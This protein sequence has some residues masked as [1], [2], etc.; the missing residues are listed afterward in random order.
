MTG[1]AIIVGT[2]FWFVMFLGFMVTFFV[3]FKGGFGGK[4]LVEGALAVII[5]VTL[6]V[7][8]SFIARKLS[9]RAIRAAG[10]DDGSDATESKGREPT[11]RVNRRSRQG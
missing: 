9:G 3:L 5:T 6:G 1:I 10:G 4:A 7:P 11:S 8:L 2:L